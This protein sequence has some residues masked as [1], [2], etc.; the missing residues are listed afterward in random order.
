MAISVIRGYNNLST[1][2]KKIPAD[3]SDKTKDKVFYE[4][5]FLNKTAYMMN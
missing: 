4:L 3:E 5:E 1:G 2:D